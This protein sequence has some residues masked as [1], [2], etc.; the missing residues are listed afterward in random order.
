MPLPRATG[1]RAISVIAFAFNSFVIF[2]T[3]VIPLLD[4]NYSPVEN[5]T[6]G[7]D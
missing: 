3:C 2:S 5:A 6:H 7:T 1:D 4:F